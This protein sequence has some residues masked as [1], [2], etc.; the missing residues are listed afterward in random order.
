MS[1]FI[2]EIDDPVQ[3]VDL[4]LFEGLLDHDPESIH[5]WLKH[6][7]YYFDIIAE[8]ASEGDITEARKMIGSAA[9]SF[10]INSQ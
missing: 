9:K 7:E 1:K 6:L 5:R 10:M 3:A 8:F 2:I 4:V